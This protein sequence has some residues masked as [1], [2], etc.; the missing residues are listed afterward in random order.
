MAICSGKFRS[1]ILWHH[2][3]VWNEFLST[4]GAFSWRWEWNENVPQW[5]LPI[6][7][8]RTLKINHNKS[9]KKIFI[10]LPKHQEKCLLLSC[11][12]ER[13]KPYRSDAARRLA[14]AS[15]RMT[16]WTKESEVSSF[17]NNLGYLE[18]IDTGQHEA[19]CWI[20]KGFKVVLNYFSCKLY[21]FL[22]CG[23]TLVT[24]GHLP[25]NDIG[26]CVDYLKKSFFLPYKYF[27]IYWCHI[28]Y[29][30]RLI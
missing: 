1:W 9:T 5:S 3:C 21:N 15:S 23:I 12:S 24:L 4:A 30:Y 22:S 26:I 8:V 25:K 17:I 6:T 18:L 28:E 29:L 10:V 16:S 7:L 14:K 2:F 19:L 11:H 20:L 13:I 27:F